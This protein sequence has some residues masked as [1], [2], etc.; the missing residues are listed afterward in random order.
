MDNRYEESNKVTIKSIILNCILSLF[1]VT[2]GIIGHSSAMI[3]DGIHSITDVIGSVVILISNFLSN[4]PADKGHNYGHEKIETLIS[5][6]ISILLIIISIQIGIQ[7]VILFF[8]LDNIIRP[9][10]LP[11]FAAIIS[12]VIKEYQFHITI[13]IANKTN[14]PTLKADAWHHRSDA[15][16]S[17]ATLIGIIG[18]LFGFMILD[19][20]VTIFV[21]VFIFKV[22]LDII[23]KSLNELIDASIDQE[24]LNKV[25]EVIKS[26]NNI[27]EIQS[28]KSRKHGPY[29]YLEVIIFV[30]EDLSVREGHN[31]ANSLELNLKENIPLIKDVIV[32]VEPHKYK[33]H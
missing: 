16:T 2:S 14:S 18:G 8:N 24:D 26:T 20:I 21:A 33:L 15:L 23:L 25:L 4:K 28:I 29:A 13:K 17:I 30:D 12:I 32:H 9:T 7:G 3:A 1:K 11:L 22:G 19:P 10:L 5:T 6:F 31:I 27:N